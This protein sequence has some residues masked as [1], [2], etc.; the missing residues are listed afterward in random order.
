M[1]EHVNFPGSL[2]WLKEDQCLESTL[3]FEKDPKTLPQSGSMDQANL[4]LFLIFQDTDFL[5]R[6]S[7]D[8]GFLAGIIKMIDSWIIDDLSLLKAP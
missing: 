3:W 8:T 2:W 4:Y 6:I 7:M 1:N 5:L